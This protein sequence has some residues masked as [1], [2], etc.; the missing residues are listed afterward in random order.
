[1]P[2]LRH[3][4][5]LTRWWQASARALVSSPSAATDRA[6]T[7]SCTSS[8]RPCRIC[9]H[10]NP[11]A[12]TAAATITTSYGWNVSSRGSSSSRSRSKSRSSSKRSR[13]GSNN[14]KDNADDMRRIRENRCISEGAAWSPAGGQIAGGHS[15]TRAAAPP[16]AAT[17]AAS[18]PCVSERRS[19]PCIHIEQLIQPR[20]HKYT[21]AGRGASTSSWKRVPAAGRARHAGRVSQAQT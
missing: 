11:P 21:K 17:A 16:R 5:D 10:N 2:L 9:R 6:N 4:H 14:S 3:E 7:R 15:A 13:R 1:M 12:M 20:L 18:W 8:L 19:M